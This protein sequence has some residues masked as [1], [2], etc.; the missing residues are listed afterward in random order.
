[1]VAEYAEAFRNEVAMIAI[2]LICSPLIAL[3]VW[4]IVFDVRK[5]RRRDPI[6]SHDIAS[7]AARARGS[8]DARGASSTEFGGG[9]AAGDQ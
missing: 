8:A 7:A 3:V 1:M 2:L 6:T 4:G 5:R 9:M